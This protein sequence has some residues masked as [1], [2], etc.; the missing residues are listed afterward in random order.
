[1]RMHI[2]WILT[3]LAGAAMAWVVI[4][5]DWIGEVAVYQIV[6]L[7]AFGESSM[8]KLKLE[9]IENRYRRD[10]DTELKADI[11]KLIGGR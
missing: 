1:M 11:T 7:L 8:N 3:L 2:K 6:A 5:M 9:A 10:S 4:E